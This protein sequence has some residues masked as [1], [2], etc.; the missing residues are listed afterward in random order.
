MPPVKKTET[1]E[2]QEEEEPEDVPEEEN[3]ERCFREGPQLYR[4]TCKARKKEHTCTFVRH[5]QGLQ[6]HA[7]VSPIARAGS[8]EGVATFQTV[9]QGVYEGCWEEDAMSGQGTYRW[10]DGSSY[11][12]FFFY[13]QLHGHGNFRWLDGTTY[14]GQWH[15]GAMH[16]QGQLDLCSNGQCLQGRFHRNYYLQAEEKSWVDALVLIRED[17]LRS[18][19]E[20]TADNLQVMRCAYGEAWAGSP[21]QDVLDEQQK[22]L[23]AA[24]VSVQHQSLVPLLIVDDSLEGSSLECLSRAG[25]LPDASSQ[26]ASIRL[27]ATAKRR[28]RGHNRFIRDPIRHSLQRGTL[29]VLVFE[30]DAGGLSQSRAGEEELGCWTSRKVV[31]GDLEAPLPED[32][33]LTHFWHESVLPLETFHPQLFNGRGLSRLFLPESLKLQS[34]CVHEDEEHQTVQAIV[35]DMAAQPPEKGGGLGLTTHIFEGSKEGLSA[36]GVP[37]AHCLRPLVASTAFFPS[38]LS[39]EDVRRLVLQKYLQHLP[40]HR[41]VVLLLGNTSGP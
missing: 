29:F 16:G 5:G 10:S 26:C 38:G 31:R 24:I 35:T 32:W 9:A 33:R 21:R 34:G 41:T 22:T 4:G 30:D 12:G 18:I 11:E 19:R 8:N 14:T 6:T 20:G 28:C 25:L 2:I 13:G 15:A 17:E 23:E 7:A 40:L 39:N 3:F 27:A 37:L 36:A 1:C